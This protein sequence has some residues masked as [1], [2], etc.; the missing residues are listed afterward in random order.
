ML[1][2]TQGTGNGSEMALDE[3]TTLAMDGIVI[4]AVDVFRPT[5]VMVQATGGEMANNRGQQL[6]GKVR[7]TTR[8]MWVDEGRMLAQLHK[9]TPHYERCWRY[10]YINGK[11]RLKVL[12][13]LRVPHSLSLSFPLGYMLQS[14]AEGCSADRGF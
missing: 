12:Q 8:G 5:S 10:Q 4:V 3:R 9:V 13:N 6:M 1:T 14:A 11:A 2:G 7:I